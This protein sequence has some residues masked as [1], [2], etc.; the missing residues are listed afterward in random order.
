MARDAV[1][2]EM[3]PQLF[4]D[5]GHEG[6]EQFQDLVDDP[7]HRGAGFDHRLLIVAG[8]DGLDEFEVPVAED[9]PDEF[10]DG[11][12]GFVELVGFEAG[13]H[14]RGGALGFAGDPAV[15]RVLDAAG[16]EVVLAHALV[17]FG[18]AGGVPELGRE[19]AIAFD[20]LLGELDVATLGGHAR[21]REAQCVGAI[22]VD[23]V[24]R[25]DDV[26]LRLR[27]LLPLLVADEGVDVDVA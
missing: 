24:E 17:H 11:A 13:G 4:G 26:A 14:A 27:H 6:V 7:R 2:D 5:E 1:L 23:D 22:G 21:E 9:A 18:E 8:E 16:I 15:E 12:G 20:G 10:I 3:R 19:V 25:V